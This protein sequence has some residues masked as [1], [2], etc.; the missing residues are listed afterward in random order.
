M[1]SRTLGVRRGQKFKAGAQRIRGERRP[2]RRAALPE[3]T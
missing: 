1:T 2:N 3:A